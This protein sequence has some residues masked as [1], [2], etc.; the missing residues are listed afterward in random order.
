M[1]IKFLYSC[2]YVQF[3]ATTADSKVIE[4][5]QFTSWPDN[6]LPENS[7]SLLAMHNKGLS[8]LSLEGPILVHCRYNNVIII[9]IT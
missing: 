2:V 7:S 6:L 4:H 1:S 3:S 8:N 5:Y 9:N